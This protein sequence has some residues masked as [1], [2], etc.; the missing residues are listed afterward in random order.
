MGIYY[1]PSNVGLRH[2]RFRQSSMRFT[3]QV[4]VLGNGNHA[5]VHTI[6]AVGRTEPRISA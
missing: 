2:H 3:N 1:T 4:K 6:R 5:V